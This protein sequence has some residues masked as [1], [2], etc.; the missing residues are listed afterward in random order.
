MPEHN[1]S[2]K[3]NTIATDRVPPG[4]KYLG[5]GGDFEPF[6][7]KRLVMWTRAKSPDWKWVP[8]HSVCD[9]PCMHYAIKK[10]SL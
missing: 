2:P 4:Y 1:T 10:G 5:R 9:V 3:E 7:E 8:S 6:P